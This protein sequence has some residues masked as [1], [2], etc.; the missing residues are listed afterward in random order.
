MPEIFAAANKGTLDKTHARKAAECIKCGSC[1]GL[2]PQHIGIITLLE[3]CAGA[4]EG[5]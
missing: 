5:N 1:E 4:S 3:K 2:C